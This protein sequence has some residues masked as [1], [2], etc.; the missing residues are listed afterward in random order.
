MNREDIE[1]QLAEQI[2]YLQRHSCTVR[3]M[4]ATDALLG[5]LLELNLLELEESYGEL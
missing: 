1:R 3:I 2:P 5:Q 4:E